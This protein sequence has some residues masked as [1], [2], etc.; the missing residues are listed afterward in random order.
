MELNSKMLELNLYEKLT[1]PMVT[2]P[3]YMI[4]YTIPNKWGLETA[5]LKK[6]VYES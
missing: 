3:P 2:H 1:K 6:Y 5:P 4:I